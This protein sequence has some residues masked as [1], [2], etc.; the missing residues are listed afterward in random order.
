MQ[1][2]HHGQKTLFHRLQQFL[3][4]C[5]QLAAIS[6][7]RGARNWLWGLRGAEV[8]HGHPCVVQ[9]VKYS[10]SFQQKADGVS[11]AGSVFDILLQ[12]SSTAAGISCLLDRSLNPHI[13]QHVDRLLK[14]ETSSTMQRYISISLLSLYLLPWNPSW[15]CAI[16]RSAPGCWPSSTHKCPFGT[17]NAAD[18]ILLNISKPDKLG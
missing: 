3:D 17:Q 13:F 7:V 11:A 5:L 16:P 10:L 2:R 12:R 1:T 9:Y 15:S 4:A 18:M 6:A 8:Q 14:I